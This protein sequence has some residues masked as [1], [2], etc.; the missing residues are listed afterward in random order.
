M[1]FEVNY[2]VEF[3][4]RGEKDDRWLWTTVEAENEEAVAKK[5]YDEKK[6]K[7]ILSIT[8]VEENNKLA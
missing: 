1:K 5:I 3:T 2:A 6:A 8:P 4:F 7:Y